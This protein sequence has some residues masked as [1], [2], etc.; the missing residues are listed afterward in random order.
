MFEATAGALEDYTVIGVGQ[1]RNDEHGHI[2][3][4]IAEIGR[5]RG[6]SAVDAFIDLAIETDLRIEMKTS[7]IAIDPLK[8]A[9][10]LRHPNVL[11][12]AS[13]GGAHTKNFSGGQWTTDLLLWLCR[14]NRFYTQEE[15]HYRFAYQP[16]R[17]MGLNDRG[18]LLEGMAADIIVY[19]LDE[20][21]FEQD[22]F[23]IL[24]DQPGGDF[25]R[26]AKAGGYRY[27]I[28]NGKVTFEA[29]QRAEATPG[30]YLA[31]SSLEPTAGKLA[32]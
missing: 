31:P 27:I 3:R 8:V 7:G 20:L 17:V 24:R 21:Y 29:D 15:L 18:A 28:V 19:S 25:R 10:L 9:E 11:A 1:G 30:L 6:V 26:K 22:R 14:E 13:D 2:G 16:A 12:G 4:T 23:E 32:A 5:E